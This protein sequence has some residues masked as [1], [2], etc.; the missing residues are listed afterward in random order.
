MKR[1]WLFL[2][3]SLFSSAIFAQAG[4]NEY[5]IRAINNQ[6]KLPG[7]QIKQILQDSE[8]YMWFATSNGLCRYNGYT[9]KMYKLS[10][11][12]P[13]L[14]QS[15]IVNTMIEDIDRRIWIGTE[16]GINIL[17]RTTDKLQ[18]IS[19]DSLPNPYI[20][21]FLLTSDSTLWV[22]TQVGLLRYNR[23][24]NNF[25][26]YK[27][28][29]NDST[30]I[31]GN[32]IRALLEDKAGYIWVATY[33]NGICRLDGKTGK[34]THYPSVTLLDR[35]N[36]LFQDMA[37]NIWI[38]AWGDG[39]IKME[40]REDNRHPVYTK[41][42]TH[43]EYEC[44]IQALQPL[45]NHEL[46]VGT[47]QGMYILDSS[48][49]LILENKHENKLYAAALN[50]DINYLYT[51]KDENIWIATQN[52]GVYVAY[53]EKTPFTNF[54]VSSMK[55]SKQQLKVNAFYEW[56]EDELLLGMDK[57][58]FVFYNKNTGQVTNYK[59]IPSYAQ[60]FQ[61]WPG[62]VQFIYK[63]PFKNEIWLGTQFGGLIVCQVKN[64]KIISC[65]YYMHRLG[66]SPIG[67][68]IN[69]IL[70]D[71]NKN[72]W[73]GSD[74]GVN[75]IT[76]TNDTLS[77]TTYNR[78]QSICQDYTG[79]IWLGTYFD[80]VYRLRP[81]VDIHKLS[82]EIYNNDNK[83]ING[84]EIL[85]IYEDSRKNLWVGTK[86][87]GLHKYNREKNWFE[88]APNMKDIP[89]DII[90]NIT[91]EK[92][93]L[94]LGTN[95]GLV[96]YNHTTYQSVILD[97]KDGLMDNTCVMNGMFNTGRGEIYYGTP[98][99]FYVFNPN[100]IEHDYT[101]VKMIIN[102][103]KIFHRS[104]DDLPARKQKQ[105]AGN[106]HPLYSKNITLT[107][108]DNNIGIE[109]AALSYVHPE[110]KRYAYKLEGFDKNWVYTDASQRTA[111]YTNLPAGNYTF[112]VKGINDSGIE[113]KGEEI[114]HIKVLPP[115]YLSGYAYMLYLVFFLG[116][117]YLFY[118]FHLYR[119]RMQEAVKIEQIER[120]KSEE[121]NQ[122]KFRFF[123]NIS[124]EFLTPLSIISCSFEEIKRNFRIEDFTRKA[125]ESNVF[126]LNKLI[127]EILEF[128][129]AENNQLK[130]SVTYG[131]VASFISGIC[132]E[133]FALLVKNKR[134]EMEICCEPEHIAAW[135]DTD[136]IDKIMYNLLSNAV[137]FSYTDGRGKIQVGIYA[138]E[139][140]SE[141]QYKKLI[142][143]VRNAGKGILADKL[144]YIFTRF[145]ETGYKQSEKRGNGIG[146]ALTKSL[147]ELH[148]GT[149][150]VTSQVEEWTEFI[151]A[152]PIYKEA[153]SVDQIDKEQEETANVS[154]LGQN[155]EPFLV[156]NHSEKNVS[157]LFVEDDSELRTSL[158]RLLSEKYQVVAASN[159]LEGLEIAC[160]MNPDLIISDVMMPKMDGF[161]LCKK[162][163]ENENTS[164]IPVIL[165]T[166][167]IDGSDHLAGLKS[168]A[169][170]Y[171]TKPFNYTI[172]EAQ[173]EN[174]L[175]NR[176]RMV[177]KFRSS[178]L[179]QAI[180]VSM[181]SYE[182]K[183][184]A[185]AIEVVK[186]NIEDPDFDVKM[187]TEQMQVSS[188]MLYRKLK[189]LT[190]L[191]P[192]EF[193]RN[194]RL[195]AA[196]ALLKEKKGNV[197]D[198]AFQI[199]F[200]DARYFSVCFKKEFNMTPGEYMERG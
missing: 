138:Q 179:T 11:Q 24:S 78:I 64:N 95:Q 36:Y 134:M 130:L 38:C 60:L 52:S 91:E 80:G 159:G 30:S 97:D 167:K 93:V 76:A 66:K 40:N 106:L 48:G 6:E 194:I 118:R 200:K 147:V 161:E 13:N 39:I 150:S 199:G 182:E 15:N 47:S 132:R 149:I 111:Y 117:A 58:S 185:T 154:F 72:L 22:G 155:T 151:V 23:K 68:T 166:A 114:F 191:S 110:K 54:P 104:F 180:D 131:D 173:I 70:M 103:F 53:R 74:E 14:L 143:K 187:F 4:W 188:S 171:I 12:A 65:K 59:D 43:T 41:F 7:K 18:T 158:S 153:F 193:I 122:S 112:H 160:R 44:I 2:W 31:C 75:I 88:P 37:K 145:Y 89:G 5:K 126:R 152:L 189:A 26:V 19:N 34:F 27:N 107:S 87:C 197:A 86:G 177:D 71:R 28:R 9:L 136:K 184:L 94:I 165:L 51:D 61:E 186:K 135:F 25:T 45:P 77:Y 16:Q 17:D 113:S 196:A 73:I 120:V 56:N 169:D 144:P 198:I 3:L 157:V 46:L 170:T 127:E 172:L 90:F 99:G 83:L 175:S 49:N 85:C 10:N 1:L 162:I 183:F 142:I 174:M 21:C 121:L 57:V 79:A 100:Q 124:H 137:K 141:F 92:G 140:V 42:N 129:K 178:P 62:N 109:F 105:L 108:G 181:T 192:N 195:K 164:H 119:F 32:S 8:G 116:S 33:G 20:H 133:N 29:P 123:T 35:T 156:E 139:Q 125:I 96:L 55:N 102:D 50:D 84:N 190:N 163:K 67:T 63:H 101:E 82:F 176:K 115:L 128:R 98:K 146:L 69:C 168:G 148:K 81:E